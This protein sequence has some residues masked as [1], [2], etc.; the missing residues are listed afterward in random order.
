MTQTTLFKFLVERLK[1]IKF[2]LLQKG[3]YG[4]YPFLGAA[5]TEYH[6]LDGLHNR[7]LLSHI[8]GVQRHKTRVLAKLVH[9]ED[10]EKFVSY[11]SPKL[12]LASGVPLAC[13]WHSSCSFTGS[14]LYMFGSVCPNVPFI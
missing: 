1:S 13:R 4:I 5:I 12:L 6:K 9:S 11:L 2:D 10:E 3:S 14:S 7:N 8:F